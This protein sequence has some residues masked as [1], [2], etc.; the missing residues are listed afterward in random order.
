MR[1]SHN[2][3]S[4]EKVRPEHKVEPILME[5]QVRKGSPPT[6]MSTIQVKFEG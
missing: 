4:V 2:S 1:E 3:D 6:G 5:Q